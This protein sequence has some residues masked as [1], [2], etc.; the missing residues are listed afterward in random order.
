VLPKLLDPF[1]LLNDDVKAERRM[2]SMFCRRSG[3]ASGM[4][5]VEILV[6]VAVA[7]ILMSVMFTMFRSSQRSY[8]TQDYVAEMQ[9]NLRVAM[10]YVSR[11]IRQAGCGFNLMS[12]LVPD[13]QVYN[14][15][16]DTANLFTLTPLTAT[17]SS[18]GPDQIEIVYGNIVTGEYNALITE[19]MP[20]SSN[21]LNLDKPEEF[22]IGDFAVITD[23]TTALLLVVTQVQP[24]SGKIG[25]SSGQS[26]WNHNNL[27]KLDSSFTGFE[28]G[29][30]LFNFGNFVWLT[31]RIDQ[32]DPTRPVLQVDRHDGLGWQVVAENIEDMQIRYLMADG[33]EIDDP[34]G[35]EKNIRA[36]RLTIVARTSQQDRD[37]RTFTPI[38]LGNPLG[39]HSP[40]AIP[41]GY[42]RTMLS[43]TIQVRNLGT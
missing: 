41:D 15:N 1:G 13:I 29:S 11:D 18:T 25:H 8:V 26:D 4:T 35:S 14:K 27:E 21:E 7:G 31:Y 20:G 17:N 37:N 6:A 30:R 22:E 24:S 3:K 12:E 38:D 9:Q 39:D 42:R 36:V 16:Y 33:T 32:S 10:Q 43:S 2:A 5:L 19:P 34:T 40:A 28:S 23:G